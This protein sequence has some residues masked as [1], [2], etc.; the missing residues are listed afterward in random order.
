M[1]LDHVLGALH[2]YRG[3]CP[4]CASPSQASACF[5]QQPETGDNLLLALCSL[6]Q[7]SSG[8]AQAVGFYSLLAFVSLS[9][10]SGYR[11]KTCV[12]L[13]W[14]VVKR[15]HS[16]DQVP[17]TWLNCLLFYCSVNKPPLSVSHS[18]VVQRFVQQKLYVFLQH[19][20]GHWPLDA[21]FRA[22]N[23]L[24]CSLTF[25]A[26]FIHRHYVLFKT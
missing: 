3:A 1:C 10:G 22:V 18:V 20:F 21:S 16:P 12:N 14:H 2:A 26:Y 6:P 13:R 19:C 24:E 7:Q 11:T 9:W 25:G 17:W 23:V 5:L 8:G 15:S 4:C